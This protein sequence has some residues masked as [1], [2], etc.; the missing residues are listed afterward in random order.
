MTDLRALAAKVSAQS[1]PNIR[2]W[3]DAVD[4]ILQPLAP[5][6]PP[7]GNKLSWAPPALTN[8]TTIQI[9]SPTRDLILDQGKDY[10]L[11]MPSTPVKPGSDGGLWT[12]GGRNIVIIGGEF[13]FT[14]VVNTSSSEDEGRVFTFNGATGVV[15]VEG[16]WAHGDGLIEG[17]QWYSDGATLQVQNCRF[18][19]LHVEAAQYHSDVIAF[20]R[21]GTLRVDRFTAS[22]ELQ[23]ISQ[24]F[25]TSTLDLRNTNLLGLTGA[26]DGSPVLSWLTA[27]VKLTNYW[28]QPRP[29][30]PV[31]YALRPNGGKVAAV[32]SISWPGSSI[33][34]SVQIGTPPGGDFC[35]LGVAGTKYVSPGY[36]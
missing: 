7:S 15:H 9:T 10:I 36:A 32:S 13:D 1:N 8:P 31:A 25:N 12:Q 33:D 27:N 22:S 30:E 21:P 17:I 2:A 35:P 20:D 29:G 3:M 16:I 28:V 11:K 26:Q 19:H 14:G 5:P 4:D 23:G 18:D 6:P 34:G 24:F